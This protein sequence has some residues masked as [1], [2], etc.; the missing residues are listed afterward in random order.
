MKVLYFTNPDINDSNLIPSIIEKSGDIVQSITTRPDVNFVKKNNIDFIV[1]DRPR[2]IIKPDLI[3]YMEKKIINLHPSFLPWNRGYNPNFWSIKENTPF[4][5]T[6]HY[7]DEGIDTGNIIVQTQLSYNKSESL[8][9]TYNR[10]RFFIVELFK[11]SWPSIRINKLPSFPQNKNEGTFHLK[12]DL[13][14]HFEKLK[15]GWDTI[16]SD[17]KCNK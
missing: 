2:F 17:I 9:S 10:L 13:D 8:K 12:K 6:I 15:D 3:N 5:V 14:E 1:S 7:I 4:G 16:I 11:S